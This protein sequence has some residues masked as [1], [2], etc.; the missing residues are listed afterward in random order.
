M[1]YQYENLSEDT[2]ERLVVQISRIYFGIGVK[3]FSKGPDG[4][5][6]S[7]FCGSAENYPSKGSPW[8]GN[9]VIQAK[10]TDYSDASFSDKNFSGENKSSVLSK[11]INS[12][13]KLIRMKYLDYYML[14]SNRSLAAQMDGKISE[15]IYTDTGLDTDN[16]SMIGKDEM[17]SIIELHPQLKRM[18][19]ELLP[20]TPLKVSAEEMAKVVFSIKSVYNND[21]NHSKLEP[22]KRTKFE[23]KN[24]INNLTKRYATKIKKDSLPFQDTFIQFLQNPVNSK[25][26]ESYSEI[27]DEMQSKIITYRDEF[28][29][30]DGIIDSICHHLYNGC[31]LL[32]SNRR[33]TRIIVELM[34]YNCDIG[35]SEE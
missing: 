2:F 10:H 15:R 26:L 16:I 30:F 11:E 1:S 17:D 29:T 23:K 25:V 20:I 5:R 18:F 24:E 14:F 32:S 4:G 12:I 3:G 6:D 31:S 9:I 35:D 33:L 34:Y 13:K 28:K 27:I 7:F 19:E 22:S 8:C 21:N